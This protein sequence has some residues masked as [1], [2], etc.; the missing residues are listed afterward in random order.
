MVQGR[1]EAQMRE[2]FMLDAKYC[3]T[4]A[5]LFLV[6]LVSVAGCAPRRHYESN[7]ITTADTPYY[8][9]EFG[10]TYYH[11]SSGRSFY[12]DDRGMRRY[13][14][15]K[16]GV[17]RI[18][19]PSGGV[20]VR[21]YVDASGRRYLIDE[22]GSRYYVENNM[23][24]IFID[25]TGNRYYV[26]ESGTKHFI[27]DGVVRTYYTDVP[28]GRIY[29]VDESGTRYYVPDVA[30]HYYID[31]NGRKFYIMDSD[32]RFII[33]ESG[34]G[35]YIVNTVPGVVR[36]QVQPLPRVV[37]PEPVQVI[38]VPEPANPREAIMLNCNSKW[39]ACFNNC[40]TLD[41]ESA[42]ASC[43]R[44]CDDDLK[45]CMRNY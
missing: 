25:D 40:N 4:Y 45:R 37:A 15:P 9:D 17:E 14:E 38:R 34:S 12:M 18:S 30:K 22:R 6:C 2:A 21:Y 24:R 42:R 32:S 33:D 13:G 23:Q 20:T 44:G 7:A 35:Y 27:R 1:S 11:D 10:K 41:R 31:E 39:N 3:S 43:A 28:S 19:G 29:Y 36:E 16:G 8:R 5:L 26:D